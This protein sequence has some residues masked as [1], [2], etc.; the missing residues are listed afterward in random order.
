MLDGKIVES[1]S[2]SLILGVSIKC[3]N[4]YAVCFIKKYIKILKRHLFTHLIQQSHFGE[5]IDPVYLPA[6]KVTLNTICC[7]F[8]IVEYWK[9]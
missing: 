1:E 3:Y 5:F 8:I 6:Y 2:F 4:A 9:Q 7:R